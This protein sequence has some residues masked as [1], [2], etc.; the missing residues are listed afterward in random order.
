MA[1]RGSLIFIP[2]S[3]ELDQHKSFFVDGVSKVVLGE[4]DNSFWGRLPVWI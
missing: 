4:S 2:W 3:I 1:K